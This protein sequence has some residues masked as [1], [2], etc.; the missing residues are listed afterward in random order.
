MLTFISLFSG[1]GGFKIGFEQAGFKCIASS[2]FDKDSQ[3]TH[4]LNWPTTPFILK[5]I[6]TLLPSELLNKTKG[7]KPDVIIGGPPCQSW[8]EAG[9]LRGI[10]DERGQLFFD[11]SLADSYN[12]GLGQGQM[13]Q[14]DGR[15]TLIAG[16]AELM[17]STSSYLDIN[18]NDL[19]K[20]GSMEGMNSGYFLEDFDLDGDVNTVDKSICLKNNGFFTTFKFE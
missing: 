4:E 12:I 13:K 20:M 7:K 3:K 14:E 9:A 15:Y 17:M 16:N 5:D 8:S 1:A 10:D 2:D 19:G 18:V 6:A 11:F